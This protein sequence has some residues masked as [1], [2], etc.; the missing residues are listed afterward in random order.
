MK[1]KFK[2]V[3]MLACLA[4][5]F[6]FVSDAFTAWRYNPF[7]R[8]LDYYSIDIGAGLVGEAAGDVLYHD[9]TNWTNLNQPGDRSC[10]Q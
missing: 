1:K 4:I 8:K 7:T 5:L 9:G 2:N 3:G 6:L 10:R